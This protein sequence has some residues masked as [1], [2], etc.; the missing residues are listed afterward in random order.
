MPQRPCEQLFSL[1][2]SNPSL[3]T[4]F[5]TARSRQHHLGLCCLPV[6]QHV[7]SCSSA[8][9]CTTDMAIGDSGVATHARAI[10]WHSGTKAWWEPGKR[11]LQ[12]HEPFPA[13]VVETRADLPTSSCPSCA[14]N[15][16]V[17]HGRS[18]PQEISIKCRAP[19]GKES[20]ATKPAYSLGGCMWE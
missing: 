7:F 19:S 9:R 17:V 10:P 8:S 12:W 18:I 15:L 3:R 1:S 5:K 6:R 13:D 4:I 2:R 16:T 20:P 11:S 14:K